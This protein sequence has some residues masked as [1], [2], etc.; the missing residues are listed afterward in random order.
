ML[1]SRTNRRAF[2]AGLGAAWP[3]VARGQQLPVVAFVGPEEDL[4]SF[5]TGL[6]QAGYADGRNVTILA[7]LLDGKFDHV[8]DVLA[9]L[10]SRQVSV[11]V[12]ITPGALAAKAATST[13]PIVFATGGD[14][15][16]LGLVSS[17][18]RPGGNL[19]GVSFFGP[20]LE[21]KRM[22]LLREMVPQTESV[23]VLLNRNGPLPERQLKE[24]NRA[25]SAL[26][27]R[28]DISQVENERDFD[29]AFSAFAQAQVGAI[30]VGAD[31][32]FYVQRQAI[33]T[34]T[35]QRRIPAMYARREFVQAGGLMSYGTTLAATFQQVGIYTGQI[36][37]GAKPADLPVLQTAKF[38]FLINLKTAKVLGI[39]PPPTLLARADEV[40]E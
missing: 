38:E 4:T 13:I 15:V 19:T 37:K 9:E 7:R 39:D 27:L 31:P 32:L 33:I 6:S 35:L 21:S 24:V 36:L 34:Q 2:I 3:L 30:L 12:S 8:G 17:L 40:I 25:A 26:G 11:I 5:R 20:L 14:P 16:E 1:V 28:L 29:S 22:G 10:V 23:G 18:N